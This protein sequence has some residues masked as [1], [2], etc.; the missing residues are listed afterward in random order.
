[1]TRSFVKKQTEILNCNILFFY[2]FLP[3]SSI[4]LLLDD[5]RNSTNVLYYI[6]V[7]DKPHK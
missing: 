5:H 3:P 1:M 7:Q 2:N 6:E 4:I